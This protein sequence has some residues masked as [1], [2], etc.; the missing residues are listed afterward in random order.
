MKATLETSEERGAAGLDAIAHR[1]S[2]VDLPAR[3]A[4]LWSC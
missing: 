3:L 4:S 2:R 1:R